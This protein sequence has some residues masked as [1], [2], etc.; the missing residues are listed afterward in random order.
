LDI[1]NQYCWFS[2]SNKCKIA[3]MPLPSKHDPEY[4]HANK[5]RLI[6]SGLHMCS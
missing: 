5:M 2:P 4:L 6:V 3:M 1:A